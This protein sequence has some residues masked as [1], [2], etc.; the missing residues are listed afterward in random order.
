[1]FS[2]DGNNQ[3]VGRTL[4]EVANS[5]N[6]TS[7]SCGG[8][9]P[10]YGVYST[11]CEAI[12]T[13]LNGTQNLISGTPGSLRLPTKSGHLTSRIIGSDERMSL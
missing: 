11:Y 2:Y 7:S 6:I 4:G 13:Q 10:F 8:Y 12:S 1:M 3:L 9:I 5:T